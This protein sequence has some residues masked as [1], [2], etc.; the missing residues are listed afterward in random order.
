MKIIIGLPPNYKE[1]TNVFNIEGHNVVFT[2][3]N[4]IYNPKR[5]EIPDHLLVHET[6]HSLQQGDNPGKWWEKYLINQDFRLAQELEAYRN[7]YN[8]Y[9]K[10]VKDRNKR[11]T[12]L[13]SI[14]KDLSSKIY[15][16]IIGRGAAIRRIKTRPN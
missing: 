8:F 9:C 15:G 6:T 7:Q 12:F 16:N 4:T 11:F 14:A 1:I 3:G 2:Y 5:G 13:Q 10:I